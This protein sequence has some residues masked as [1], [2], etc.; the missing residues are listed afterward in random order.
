M[1]MCIL[2]ASSTKLFVLVWAVLHLKN[3]YFLS[4]FDV[5]VFILLPILL[6]PI[7]IVILIA[8]KTTAYI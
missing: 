7:L 5:Y 3:C 1:I 6:F 2:E 4:V 8:I